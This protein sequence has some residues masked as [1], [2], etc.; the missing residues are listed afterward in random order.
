MTT[1]TAEPSWQRQA[2]EKRETVLSLI[3][4]EWR[5]HVPDVGEQRDVSGKYLDQY[6]T[7]K[8]IEI[9]D[10]D[11]EGIVKKTSTGSWSA[12]EVI[13]A[14]AHRAALAHQLV[15]EAMRGWWYDE[16]S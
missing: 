10:T 7:E 15:R 14:F 13:T 3:P 4:E 9:T 5:I 16:E 11:A 8:E 1:P 2:R 12:E 6:L